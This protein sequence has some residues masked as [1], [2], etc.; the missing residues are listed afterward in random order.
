MY[1]FISIIIR[2]IIVVIRVIILIKTHYSGALMVTKPDGY[3]KM[4]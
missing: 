3:C 1:V 2:I 4:E